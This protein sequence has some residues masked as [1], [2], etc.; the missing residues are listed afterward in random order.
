MKMTLLATTMVLAILMELMDMGNVAMAILTPLMDLASNELQVI[1]PGDRGYISLFN[2][3]VRHG[4]ATEDIYVSG[5]YT[6]NTSQT[7]FI[8]A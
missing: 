3:E 7:N 4:E 8:K 2:P 6:C 1:R 5:C